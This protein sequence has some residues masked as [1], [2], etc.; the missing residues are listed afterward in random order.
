[1]LVC[2]AVPRRL[3]ITPKFIT[4]TQELESLAIVFAR[5]GDLLRARRGLCRLLLGA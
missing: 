3:E 5:S 2:P 1:M 4:K